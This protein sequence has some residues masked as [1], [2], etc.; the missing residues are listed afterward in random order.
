MLL[1][2]NAT[3]KIS[4]IL[5]IITTLKERSRSVR[6]TLFNIFFLHRSNAFFERRYNGGNSF[7]QG[8]KSTRRYRAGT[9][10]TDIS[11]INGIGITSKGMCLSV[12]CAW[13]S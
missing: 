8:D 7:Y 12:P 1:G 2:R 11:A 6:N 9:N 4:A 3:N 10:L 5:P 13:P